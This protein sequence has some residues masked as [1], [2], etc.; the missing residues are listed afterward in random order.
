MTTGANQ[1]FGIKDF[2]EGVD[3]YYLFMK[4]LAGG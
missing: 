3:F 4:S 1:R 2:F